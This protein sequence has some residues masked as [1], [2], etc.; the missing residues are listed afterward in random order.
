MKNLLDFSI[1]IVLMHQTG[2]FSRKHPDSWVLPPV[3]S[4]G[5]SVW[6]KNADDHTTTS[7]NNNSR[8]KPEI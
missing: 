3:T 8:A 4:K 7:V 2:I 1:F 6:K 5:H